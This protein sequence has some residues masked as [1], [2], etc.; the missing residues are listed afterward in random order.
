V[1]QCEGSARV[2][3]L[4]FHETINTSECTRREKEKNPLDSSKDRVSETPMRSAV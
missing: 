3:Y 1:F 4:A 2:R